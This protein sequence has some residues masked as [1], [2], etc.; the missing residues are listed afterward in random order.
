[1]YYTACTNVYVAAMGYSGKIRAMAVW[2]ECAPGTHRSWISSETVIL[3]K[4]KH[5][6]ERT[7]VRG[8]QMIVMEYVDGDTVAAL[9]KKMG[10]DMKDLV[11]KPQ[12]S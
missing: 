2:G 4:A 9:K 3:G 11:I 10:D 1:M 7:V 6:V 5:E 8:I 12:E